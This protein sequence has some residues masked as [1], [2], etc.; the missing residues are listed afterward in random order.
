MVERLDQTLHDVVHIREVALHLPVVVNLDGLARQDGFHKLEGRHVWPAPGAVDGEEAKSRHGN[1]KQV[2]VGVAHELVGLFGGRIKRDGVVHRLGLRKRQRFVAPVHARGTRVDEVRAAAVI[3][4]AQPQRLSLRP[5]AL[6]NIQKACD[7][8]VDIGMG[9][10]EGVP[11]PGLGC[12]VNHSIEGVGIEERSHGGLVFEARLHKGEA[13]RAR[14]FLNA[15][16]AGLFEC[17][18]VIV[19]EV[20]EP[21]HG[22][23][24]GQE[25]LAHEVANEAGCAGDEY[26]FQKNQ[27]FS[28]VMN[29]RDAS[30]SEITQCIE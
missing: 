3:V 27:T 12:K 28:E 16:Q 8:A 1:A 26:F 18:V 24:P 5:N 23:A 9:V 17:G 21:H 14:P 2:A 15:R 4:L 13:L 22:I 10:G 7:V 11:H 25:P 6:Q 29:R 20:V 19:V 30:L